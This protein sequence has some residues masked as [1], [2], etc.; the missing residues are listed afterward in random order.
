MSAMKAKWVQYLARPVSSWRGRGA[1]FRRAIRKGVI[2]I[3]ANDGGARRPYA[4]RGVNVL[5][6]EP[7][8]DVFARLSAN[9]A[10]LPKQRALNYLVVDRD[11]T[12]YPFNVSSNQG[13][14][15]SILPYAGLKDIWPDI[16]VVATRTIVGR[17][18]P[19]ILE[20][21][22]IDLGD[23]DA[24]LV[25]TEGSEQMVLTGAAPLLRHFRWIR[26]EAAEFETFVGSPT[27][28]SIGR[29]MRDHG[30]RE[31]GRRQ[32]ATHPAGGGFFDVLYAPARI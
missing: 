23:Y 14:S 3:G 7:D 17:T 5:W 21:E 2:H 18:L 31:W 15:S 27:V 4:E 24:M 19:A 32:F 1:T 11:L 26:V 22:G 10:G 28:E 9:I 16:E 25:D 8:P 30:F 20:K 6:I 13:L 29:F 12:P